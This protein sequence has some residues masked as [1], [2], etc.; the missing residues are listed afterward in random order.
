VKRAA[1]W[2]RVGEIGP[3]DRKVGED[4]PSCFSFLF[5]KKKPLDQKEEYVLHK[6]LDLVATRHDGYIVVALLFRQFK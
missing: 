3:A 2:R 1:C 5:F 4:F 6:P